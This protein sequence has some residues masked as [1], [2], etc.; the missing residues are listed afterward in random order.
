VAT[1]SVS[2]NLRGV[3]VLTLESRR[4]EEFVGLLEKRGATVE[5][6]PSLREVPLSEQPQVFAFGEELFAG[7]CEAMLL[8]TGVGTEM[9]V[10]TLALRHPRGVIIEH[11]S[12]VR[13]YC[14]G[15][16]PVATLRKLGLV[17]RA[18]APEPNTWRELIGTLAADAPWT[19]T[20]RNTASE[21]SA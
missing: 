5:S 13:L 18:V 20:S 9:L 3:T 4:S 12:R 16:K 7:T 19:G 6:A 8:L 17:P 1:G 21:T 11:L 10:D 15:P 14:R 2:D